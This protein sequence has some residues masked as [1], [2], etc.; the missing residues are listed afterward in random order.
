MSDSHD[1]TADPGALSR[2]FRPV[3]ISSLVAFR[4]ILGGCMLWE[5][6]RYWL[7][8]YFRE[9]LITP[10]FHF[11]FYG[12]SWVGELPE[13]WMQVVFLLLVVS[14]F[15]VLV[16]A[17]YR[18][19]CL[20]MF[21]TFSYTFLLEATAYR[22]HVYLLALLSFLM[23]F[24]PAHRAYSFDARRRP[25]TGSLTTPVWTIWL[26]RF[27]L[28]AVYFFAGVAKF[29]PD[30]I[31]GRSLEAIFRS[32]GHSP[33]LVSFLL[34][35]WVTHFFVW[36]GLCFDLLITFALLWR[37]TRLLSYIG[38]SSFHLVN[39]TFL[40]SVG[41]FPW[42]MLFATTIFFDPNWPREVLSRL[43]LP[44]RR[45]IPEVEDSAAPVR[46]DAMRR[47][48]VGLLALYVSIQ[49]L[50]P[51]RQHLYPGDTAWTHQGH[52]WAWRMKLVAKA[53]TDIRLRSVDPVT[54]DEVNLDPNLRVL[55]PWQVER[56]ARQPDLTLQFVHALHDRI[57]EQTGKDLPIYADIL[58]S[59]NGRP[60]MPIL[61]PNVDLVGV[62]WSI[63]PNP[64][65]VPL[66]PGVR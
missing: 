1:R 24:L 17:F 48:V 59:L 58:V 47:C 14:S 57:L 26:L 33:E 35:G 20:V 4:I 31:A 65:I 46:L 19:S 40:V 16:G 60:P 6:T 2:L 39:G 45:L 54:F 38:A 18:V 9:Y 66:P 5:N 29:D 3:D 44:I 62:P 27:Q 8:G 34:Q 56:M 51:L 61:D 32:E 53:A 49:V 12:F 64:A 25:E 23:I 43:G 22:N 55:L 11:K 42:F 37:R 15:G 63:R 30:W 13:F 41:I 50:L 52:R 21:L 7:A 28:G 10:E 36:S